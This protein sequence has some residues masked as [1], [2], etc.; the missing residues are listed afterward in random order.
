MIDEIEVVKIELDVCKI[1]DYYKDCDAVNAHLVNP[2]Y[3]KLPQ[4]LEKK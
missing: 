1:V 4:V 3:L 2:N